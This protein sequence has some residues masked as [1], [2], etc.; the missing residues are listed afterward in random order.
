MS[1]G[2]SPPYVD[3]GCYRLEPVRPLDLLVVGLLVR[4]LNLLQA[5]G[6]AL[7]GDGRQ[8][9][10]RTAVAPMLSSPQAVFADPVAQLAALDPIAALAALSP[11]AALS[12]LSPTLRMF[13]PAINPRAALLAFNPAAAPALAVFHPPAVALPPPAL[14]LPPWFVP[15]PWLAPPAWLAPGAR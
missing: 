10:T 4:I 14:A 15:P 6:G 8:A 5:G 11:V 1:R 7:G 2:T 3:R 13:N 12:A 9:A